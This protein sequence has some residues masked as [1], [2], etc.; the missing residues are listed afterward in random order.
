MHRLLQLVQPADLYMGQKDYQQCMVVKKLLQ[1]T[2]ISTN[3]HTCPTL[4]E[5]DGLAMS[6]R[7]MRLNAEDRQTAVAISAVLD[8]VC[9]SV[10]PGPLEPVAASA[11][12]AL[13]EKGFIVDY[14][15]IAAADTLEILEEWDG[16]RPLVTLA[17]AFLHEVRLIDNKLIPA[18]THK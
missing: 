18:Y 2:G 14:V 12:Q 11:E 1:L 3:F 6:S 7:N 17:A 4:R 8:L 13:T 16:Q 15:S 10:I 9:A 5:P